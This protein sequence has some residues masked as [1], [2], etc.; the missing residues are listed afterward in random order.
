[1]VRCY[2][3]VLGDAKG[4]GRAR[5]RRSRGDGFNELFNQSLVC[6]LR[7]LLHTLIQKLALYVIVQCGSTAHTAIFGVGKL[8]HEAP[9][10]A[11][12]QACR[13]NHIGAMLRHLI[14]DVLE[15]ENL[16]LVRHS[17]LLDAACCLVGGICPVE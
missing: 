14:A 15:V 13:S 9:L 10:L 11:D 12:P 16:P 5:G 17:F 3:L 6:L 8:G 1:M 4:Q 7:L 2:L